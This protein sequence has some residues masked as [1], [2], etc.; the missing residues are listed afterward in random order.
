MIKGKKPFITEVETETS[1]TISIQSYITDSENMRYY[2]QDNIWNF[3]ITS[4]MTD[5]TD[6]TH[7]FEYE[8]QYLLSVIAPSDSSRK[9]GWY[10]KESLISLNTPNEIIIS[11][12]EKDVFDS[13]LIG[14]SEERDSNISFIIRSPLVIEAVYH[15]EYFLQL[16]S[17]YGNPTGFGWYEDGSTATI[18]IEKEFAMP[19]IF[20][21]LGGKVIFEKWNSEIQSQN[22]IA[23]VYMDSSKI[24]TAYWRDDYTITFIISALMLLII[25]TLTTRIVLKRHKKKFEIIPQ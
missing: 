2:C 5:D 12:G 7:A 24:I 21:F 23:N 22:N 4:L 6:I 10:N 20:G 25:T 16:N 15:R 17:I 9:S 18:S 1:H 8:P 19:G 3:D 13:W 11:Q 14:N